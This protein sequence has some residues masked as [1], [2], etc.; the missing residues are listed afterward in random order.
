MG[1]DLG[2]AGV[3]AAELRPTKSGTV[4]ERFGQVALPAGAVRDGE[5]VDPAAVA[6]AVKQLWSQ[7]RF[8]SKRVV[9]GVANQKVVVRQVELPWLPAGELKASLA[10]QVQDFIPMPVEHAVLDAHPLEEFQG[11]GGAR[12]LRVLL[13][14][15]ARDMVGSAVDAV[16]RAGLAP[17]MVDLTA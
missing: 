8:A 14:A 11:E 7:A 16:N 4:L 10:F 2:T 9:L 1:L 13:V 12:M 3:R 6:S 5:V 15:A 17:S